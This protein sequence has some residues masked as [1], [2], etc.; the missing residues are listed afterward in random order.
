MQTEILYIYKELQNNPLLYSVMKI[1][2][3]LKDN[4]GAIRIIKETVKSLSN[5]K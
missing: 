2:L 5:G 3:E 4:P 1:E